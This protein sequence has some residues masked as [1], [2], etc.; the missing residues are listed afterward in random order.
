MKQADG[1]YYRFPY[2]ELIHP[3]CFTVCQI[4]P[5]VDK[6][7][8]FDRN[9]VKFV[10]VLKEHREVSLRMKLPKGKYVIIPSTRN[11]GEIGKFHLSVYFNQKIRKIK[12]IERID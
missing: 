5:N 2:T 1:N 4:P 3:A 11:P 12:E 9:M 7:T 8:T 10:S 6:V